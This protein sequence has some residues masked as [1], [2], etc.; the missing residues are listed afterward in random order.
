MI[1]NDIIKEV[2]LDNRFF[3]VTK[4]YIVALSLMH[5]VVFSF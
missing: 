3:F 1:L 2:V 5:C 4:M